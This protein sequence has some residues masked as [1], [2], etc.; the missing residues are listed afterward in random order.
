MSQRWYWRS[1]NGRTT[2]LT[3]ATY[4][5]K[6]MFSSRL[7]RVLT[8]R[9]LTVGDAGVYRCEATYRTS[10]TADMT[11]SAEAQLTVHGIY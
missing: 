9:K 1:K 5:G 7:R 6:Y 11:F 2:E 8:I 3:S 10:S 4:T